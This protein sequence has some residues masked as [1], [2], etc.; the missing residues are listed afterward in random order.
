MFVN[1]ICVATYL[2]F[3]DMFVNWKFKSLFSDVVSKP[4]ATYKVM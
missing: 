3:F 2:S 1:I 4:F